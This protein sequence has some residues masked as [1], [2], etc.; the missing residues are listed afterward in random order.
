MSLLSSILSIFSAIFEYLQLY[1]WTT[2]HIT[3]GS[4]K[5]ASDEAKTYEQ[6]LHNQQVLD[7]LEDLHEW[8][9]E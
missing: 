7:D 3:V 2:G 8:Y 5:R 1:L 6:W 9:V 4:V